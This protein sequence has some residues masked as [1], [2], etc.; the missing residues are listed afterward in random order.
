MTRTTLKALWFGGGGILA[1]WLAVSPDHAV[2][3]GTS[4][5]DQRASVVADRTAEE[6]NAKATLLRDRTNAAVVQRSTRN[7]FRFNSRHA[8]PPAQR[9]IPQP[10]PVAVAPPATPAAP[11]LTLSGVAQKAGKRTAILSAGGQIYIA[12]EGDTVAG[13]FTVVRV[14]PEAVVLRDQNGTEERLALK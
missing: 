4:P 11:R 2:P 12:A 14:D 1:T 7:P 8:A 6:L 10:A 9:A 3:A 5:H 13:S